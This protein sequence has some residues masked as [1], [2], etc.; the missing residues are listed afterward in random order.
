MQRAYTPVRW[1]YS[2]PAIV[3]HWLLAALIVFMAALGWWMMTVEHEPGGE[4]WFDLHKSIGLILLALVALRLLWRL[5]HRPEPLPPG[6]PVWQVRLSTIT[7]VLLYVMMVLVP[8]M[9]VLGA[10]YS[11]AGLSFFGHDLPHWVTANRPTAKQFFELH[12]TL[13]WVLV[14][15]VAVHV[16]GGLKHLLVDRDQVFERMWPRRP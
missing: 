14:A 10:M 13:V 9:G 12:E 11:R 4:R 6:V 16:V 1:R 5:G 2:T 15:L 8:L 7:Q 3:L